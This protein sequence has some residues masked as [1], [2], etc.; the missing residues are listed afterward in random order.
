VGGAPEVV[1]FGAYA[2][3]PTVSV[4]FLSL[5][6]NS[7]TLGVRTSANAPGKAPGDPASAGTPSPR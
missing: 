6:L 3:L 1:R 4:D 2:L 7:S 5:T